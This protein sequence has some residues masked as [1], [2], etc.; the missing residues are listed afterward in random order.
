[1]HEYIHSVPSPDKRIPHMSKQLA[2]LSSI[3]GNN[4]NMHPPMATFYNK[5]DLDEYLAASEGYL[6]DREEEELWTFVK[7]RAHRA[8]TPASY[9]DLQDEAMRVAR[10][11]RSEDGKQFW[12]SA[13]EGGS[14]DEAFEYI[15]G[16]AAAFKVNTLRCFSSVE[17]GDGDAPSPVIRLEQPPPPAPSGGRCCGGAATRHAAA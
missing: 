7:Q 15:I 12:G 3:F 6:A 5:T 8:P 10:A 9:Q 14:V 13:K 16:Q 11:G 4:A 17:L 1:M 2:R